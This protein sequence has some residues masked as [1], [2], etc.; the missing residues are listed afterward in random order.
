MQK[1]KEEAQMSACSRRIKCCVSS[2]EVP[3]PWAV[4][5]DTEGVGLLLVTLACSE[6]ALIFIYLF[7]H[8]TRQYFYKN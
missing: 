1:E 4:S 7:V 6:R 8:P 2:G 3:Q 5:V